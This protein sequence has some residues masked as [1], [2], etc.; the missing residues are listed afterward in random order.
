MESKKD[1]LL[2]FFLLNKSYFKGE[3]GRIILFEFRI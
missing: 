3:K 2:K 1:I